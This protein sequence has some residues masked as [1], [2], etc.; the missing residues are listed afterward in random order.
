MNSDVKSGRLL[1][2]AVTSSYILHYSE[3]RPFRKTEE[4]YKRFLLDVFS[5]KYYLEFEGGS[6]FIDL[7]WFR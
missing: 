4:N 6:Q 3:F 1:D 7:F 2:E 5:T